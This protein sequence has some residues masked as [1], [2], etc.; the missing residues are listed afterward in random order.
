MP[1]YRHALQFGT[2]ITPS[3]AAPEAVVQRA[4]FS[5][6]LG[7]DLVTFQDHPYQAGFL[8]TWTLL[9]FV[10]ARTERIHL[11]GN[12]LNLPMRPAPVLARAAS[13]LDLLSGGRFELGLGAG[14]FWDAMAAMGVKRLTPGQGVDALSEGIE[15]IKAIWDADERRPLHFD[16]D[17]YQL[18]GTKRG[19]RP[20]HE[21][22]IWLGALKPRMLRL[23]GEKAD[24][25]L[26]S[27]AYLLPGDLEKGNAAIDA[28]AIEAGRDPREVRRMLNVG[29]QFSARNAGQLNGP[30]DQWVDELSELALEHGASTFILA[31]DDPSMMQQFAEEVVPGVRERIAAERGSGDTV[32]STSAISLRRDGIRYDDVPESLRATAVEPGDFG[33]ARVKSN[34]MRGGA[35]GIVLQPRTAGEVAE[36]LAFARL[37]P[38]H[39]LGVRSGGHGISGRSTNDGGIIID[40]RNFAEIEVIGER[41]VRVGAGARWTDVAAALEPHGW[42]LSSGDYGG[43][44]VGGLATA[45]GV[46]WLTRK[47]GLTID[48]VRSVDVVLAD[49]S[50]VTAS[51]SDNPDLFWAMR[52]AGANFGIA[53]SFEFE[54]DE[55]GSVGY[56]QLVFDASDTAGFLVRWGA[57]VEDAPREVTSFVYL[58]GSRPGQPQ[59][60]QVMA[61]VDSDDPDTIL[62]MLQPFAQIAPLADQSVEL[63]PYASVM[64]NMQSGPHQGSGEPVSRSGLVEHFTPE[65]AAASSRLI[66]SGASHFFSIRAVGGAVADIAPDETAYAHRSANFSLAVLGSNAQRLDDQWAAIEPFSIGSYLSFETREGVDIVEQA[67]PPATLERLRSLKATYDPAN[68]FRDN[69]NVA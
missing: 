18:D 60:A 61:V 51:A 13:S 16:G 34:Y 27:L 15:V 41:R 10:A 55:V 32:R 52:G 48:H 57:A 22:P 21:I 38:E 68:V 6:Q 24:G 65:L 17:Y 69:F 20:A 42:A 3:N 53:L 9:S 31:S 2:F 30:A 54:V 11:S 37:H 46:G 33:Y 26:P 67:F 25:W 63:K 44:G 64:A 40:L 14:A 56:A 35:P 36:A 62:E 66:A 1:D 43:V 7:F 47:H 23:V 45:G 58:G 39:P 12:V 50:L 19:P 29:G 59:L 49:G 5:E 28:S 4:V 8:D